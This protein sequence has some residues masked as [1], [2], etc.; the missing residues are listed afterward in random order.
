MTWTDPLSGPRRHKLLTEAI[1]KAIPPLGHYSEDSSLED[2]EGVTPHAKVFSPYS[3]HRWYFLE[4]DP[5]TGE[6]YGM[7]EHLGATEFGY[8]NINELAQATFMKT[9]PAIERDLYWTPTPIQSIRD[10]A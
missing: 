9:V 7:V 3:G 4:L 5:S 6:A 10:A 8:F 1:I 2:L